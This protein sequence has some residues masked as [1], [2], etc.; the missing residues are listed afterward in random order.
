MALRSV[1]DIEVNSASFDAFHQKFSAWQQAAANQQ[2]LVV[3]AGGG[4]AGIGNAIKDQQNKAS[5]EYEKQARFGEQLKRSWDSMRDSSKHVQRNLQSITST[6]M[7]FTGLMGLATGVATGFGFFGMD[8]LAQSAAGW[9]RSS[10]GLGASIGGQRAFNLDYS[11]AFDTNQVLGNVSAAM[12]DPSK[13]KL[14]S[15]M[16]VGFSDNEDAADVAVRL[17]N[18]VRR[19]AKNTSEENLGSFV[20]SHGLEGTYSLQDIQ[21]MRSMS[22]E[23]WNAQGA[24]FSSDKGDLNLSTGMARQWTDFQNQLSR[25]GMQIENIF[26]RQLTPLAP[27]FGKLSS[28]FEKTISNLLDVAKDSGFID[29]LAHAVDSFADYVKTPEFQQ[30]VRDFA[31]GV[32]K[33]AKAI[34]GFVTWL[35]GKLP[36]GVTDGP[37]PLVGGGAAPT[38]GTYIEGTGTA[39]GAGK[40]YRMPDGTVQDAEGRTYQNI[41]GPG[42]VQSWQAITGPKGAGMGGGGGGSRG[43]D[44]SA[45]DPAILNQK[46]KN[47][48]G[49][50]EGFA[51]LEKQRDLPAGI[52]DSVWAQESGRGTNMLSRAGAKGHFQFMDPTAKRFGLTDPNDLGQ[53]ADAASRYLHSNLV[54]FNG[55]IRKALAGYNWG[56]GNVDAA[57]AKYGDKWEDYAPDETKK[58]IR[59]ILARRENAQHPTA[60]PGEVVP[61]GTHR[62]TPMASANPP[63]SPHVTVKIQNETGGNAIASTAQVGGLYA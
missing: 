53:S 60:S 5:Q 49:A 50:Q 56:E 4:R 25:A 12:R 61:P 39:L 54:K 28:A 29:T 58:Y 9:R 63:R 34:G 18:E 36:A 30:G 35:V 16:G 38:G 6:M 27:A 21:R 55:D 48:M 41:A 57:V 11:R 14:L 1:L 19:Q 10:L 59:Q 44:Q 2:P 7:R 32:V 23:E 47:G 37:D 22:D 42:E 13:R 40:K 31:N 20:T 8:K 43:E 46:F 26:V 15:A 33:M 52:L 45:T 3:A 62:F 17:S 24:H 51:M